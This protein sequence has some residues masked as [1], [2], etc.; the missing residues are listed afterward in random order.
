MRFFERIAYAILLVLVGMIIGSSWVLH[1]IGPQIEK[2]SKEIA[3]QDDQISLLKVQK[4]ITRLNK[5]GLKK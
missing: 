3:R 4:E 2:L 5:K 1:E